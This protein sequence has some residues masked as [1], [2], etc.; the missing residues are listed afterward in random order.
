MRAKFKN[1]LIKLL[2]SGNIENIQLAE[3]IMNEKKQEFMKKDL[4]YM[5]NKNNSNWDSRAV[6]IRLHSELYFRE[7]TKKINETII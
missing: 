6:I 2:N 5:F 1:T 4:I 7:R 3:T